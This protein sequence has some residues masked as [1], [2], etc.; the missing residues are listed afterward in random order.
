[1]QSIAISSTFFSALPGVLRAFVRKF[2]I[3]KKAAKIFGG[4]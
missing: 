4:L 2:I 3:Q 1:L